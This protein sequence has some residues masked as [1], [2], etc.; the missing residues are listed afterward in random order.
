VLVMLTWEDGSGNVY[1]A[2]DLLMPSTC[3]D[4][5]NHPNYVD[6]DFR[7]NCGDITGTDSD[8]GHNC[9]PV[10]IY[11]RSFNRTDNTHTVY[12]R[13]YINES[14]WNQKQI[15]SS[16]NDLYADITVMDLD[17][18]FT[19]AN[20]IDIVTC[21]GCSPP[22][23]APLSPTLLTASYQA[24]GKV[25]LT[26]QASSSGEPADFYRIYRCLASMNMSDND[27]IGIT[28]L[29]EYLDDDYDL[30]SNESYKYAVAGVNWAGEGYN[31]NE[32]AITL[33]CY[34][35]EISNKVYMGYAAEN[36][37]NL[38]IH[39]VEI[40]SGANVVFDA[41]ENITISGNFTIEVGAEISLQ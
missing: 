38:S 3:T 23:E 14:F 39:D 40:K 41:D 22:D 30:V 16:L 17:F 15:F 24:T 33:P 32:L 35:K 8:V 37:C 31:S 25:N 2:A 34:T 10:G 1:D 7:I 29:T 11:P 28:T 36:G 19:R 21:I 9:D 13:W 4:F 26:W 12:F 5:P 6:Y 27:I 18:H 20:N